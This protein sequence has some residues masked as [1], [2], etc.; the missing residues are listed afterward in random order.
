MRIDD[1]EIRDV[2]ELSKAE[3]IEM[4]QLKAEI[5]FLM[6]VVAN[7]QEKMAFWSVD[8]DLDHLL[9]QRAVEVREHAFSNEKPADWAYEEKIGDLCLPEG[10]ETA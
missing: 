7:N 5:E 3:L 2:R 9:R 1:R 10:D 8:A 6:Y 4:E